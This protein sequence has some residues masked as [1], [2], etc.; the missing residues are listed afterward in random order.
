ML[1]FALGIKYQRL[2]CKERF[3]FAFRFRLCEDSCDFKPFASLFLYL[4]RVSW[5][6]NVIG[7]SVL[8]RFT[9]E[10]VIEI[11][12]DPSLDCTLDDNAT[13]DA[14]SDKMGFRERILQPR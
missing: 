9:V 5:G 14:S 11:G 12:N 2:S 10:E 4:L 8:F 1:I 6:L 13:L 7:L 3:I